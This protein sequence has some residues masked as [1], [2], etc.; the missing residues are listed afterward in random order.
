MVSFTP[1]VSVIVP[2]YNASHKLVFSIESLL[3]QTLQGLEIIIVND[4]ST[5]DTADVIDRLARYHTNIVPV[6]FN[7]NKGVHEARLAGLKKSSSPWIGF[8]DADDFAR[9]NMFAKLL[10]AAVGNDVDIVVCGS[11]RVT[12]QRKVI[13]PKLRF[14]NSQKVDINIFERFCSFDFG[15]GMLWNKLYKREIIESCFDLH[16]VWRQSINEDLLLNIGCFYNSNSVFL[17]KDIL[18]EYVFS[19]D[20]VTARM[21]NSWAYVEIY[22]AF[23]LA[24][25]CY[26]HLDSSKMTCIID[27]YRRQLSWN[28]YQLPKTVELAGYKQKLEEATKLLNNENPY[29]LAAI[30]ARKPGAVVGVNEAIKSLLIAIVRRLQ[31]VSSHHG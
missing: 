7:E 22:R 1:T 29:A 12:E 26:Q 28:N 20:S 13:G 30:A 19:E 2:V 4:A 11:D 15:A 8:I 24:M 3:N 6:H 31:K 21:N 14:K 5:D 25:T 16:F 10:T 9:P 27:M 23:A 17:L 18:H